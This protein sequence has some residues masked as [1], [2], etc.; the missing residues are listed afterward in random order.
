MKI[1]KKL[2]FLLTSVWWKPR[3]ASSSLI[4]DSGEFILTILVGGRSVSI[5]SGSFDILFKIILFSFQSLKLFYF[6]FSQAK[7]TSRDLLT[8]LLLAEREIR[9]P[10][11]L[12]LFVFSYFP[13]NTRAQVT[14]DAQS[15]RVQV[16]CL[17]LSTSLV[18]GVK[19][20]VRQ[21]FHRLRRLWTL[22]ININRPGCATRSIFESF[23]EKL[24]ASNWFPPNDSELEFTILFL[25]QKLR[26]LYF[27][28]NRQLSVFTIFFLV[29]IKADN[30]SSS[31]RTTDLR[32]RRLKTEQHIFFSS[33]H[34]AQCEK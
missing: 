8:L 28:D 19:P 34:D 7:I 23:L 33:P 21:P 10:N 6:L 15:T 3:P 30:R 27:L 22:P 5:R 2:L 32:D 25:M 16:H 9:R 20:M 29:E 31:C 14:I 17:H 13:I 18:S 4:A 1:L 24:F 11:F 12:C 26:K